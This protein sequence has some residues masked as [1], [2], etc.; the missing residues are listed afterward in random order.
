MVTNNK[1]LEALGV[2]WIHSARVE[3]AR[4]KTS[5]ALTQKVII[6]L[7]SPVYKSWKHIVKNTILNKRAM[8]N[9]TDNLLSHLQQSIL[10]TNYILKHY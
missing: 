1:L 2:F 9:K 4:H 3:S 5:Y 8:E 6:T 7:N 10:C